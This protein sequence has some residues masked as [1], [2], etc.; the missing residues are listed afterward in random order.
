MNDKIESS[1]GIGCL[2]VVWIVFFILKLCG[3]VTWSWWWVMSP[4]IL[5]IALTILLVIFVGGIVVM[6]HTESNKK[7][8]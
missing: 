3:L 4:F 7:N 1:N 5:G 2:T 8:E 6:E